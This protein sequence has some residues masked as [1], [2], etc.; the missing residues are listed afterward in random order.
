MAIKPKCDRCKKELNV[1]GAL[2]FSPPVSVEQASSVTKF[3]V[4][5]EGCFDAMVKW[6]ADGAEPAALLKFVKEGW[7]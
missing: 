2:V 1:P 6:L 4:C 3:H 5:D 7:K